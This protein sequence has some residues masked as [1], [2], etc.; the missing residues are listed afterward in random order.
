MDVGLPGLAA[1][2]WCLGPVRSLAEAHR[3]LAVTLPASGRVKVCHGPGCVA[4]APDR[5]PK[6]RYGR[7][8]SLGPFRCT[9]LRTGVR[10]VVKK[11]D[12]GFLLLRR[13]SVMRL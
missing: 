12:H 5:E 4:N 2:V 3:A 6:L 8:I 13:H 1:R 10:C 9:S 7:S 11:L